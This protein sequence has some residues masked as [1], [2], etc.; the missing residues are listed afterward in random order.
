MLKI[1]DGLIFE[2]MYYLD[3][4]KSEKESAFV[5]KVFLHSNA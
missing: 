4:K 1:Y 2:R 5:Q 3:M